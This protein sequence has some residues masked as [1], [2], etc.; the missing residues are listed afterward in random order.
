MLNL[1]GQAQT[2]G[3]APSIL[4]SA[5]ATIKMLKKDENLPFEDKTGTRVFLSKVT[6]S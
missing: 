5:L 3:Y 6:T 2:L 4:L 1:W